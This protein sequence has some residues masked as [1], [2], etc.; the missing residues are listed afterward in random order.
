MYVVLNGR[1]DSI[2]NMVLLQLLVYLLLLLF[3]LSSRP[4]EDRVSK[5]LVFLIVLYVLSYR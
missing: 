4:D 5:A 3:S 2:L 1:L